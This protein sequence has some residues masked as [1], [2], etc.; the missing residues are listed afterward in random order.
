MWA[1]M[2]KYEFQLPVGG[3]D[4]PP[5]SVASPHAKIRSRQSDDAH[6]V[7][8]KESLIHY[9]LQRHLFKIQAVIQD[10]HLRQLAEA[11][12][13]TIPVLMNRIAEDAVILY[14]VCGDHRQLA[15]KAAA[16]EC[17]RNINFKKIPISKLFI[18]PKNSPFD[19]IIRAYGDVDN[20]ISSIHKEVAT[21]DLLDLIRAN[22]NDMIEADRTKPREKCIAS[23]KVTWAE[24]LQ[25]D[26]RGSRTNLGMYVDMA[27]RPDEQYELLSK[28]MRG[29]IKTSSGK[30]SSAVRQTAWFCQSITNIS[31]DV[32]LE[33]L[34]DVAEGNS[35]TAQ[36]TVE[37]RKHRARM[38]VEERIIETLNAAS[39]SSPRDMCLSIAKCKSRYMGF[40]NEFTETFWNFCMEPNQVWKS[41]SSGIEINSRIA[42]EILYKCQRLVARDMACNVA[43]SS[44]LFFIDLFYICLPSHTH[45]LAL[46]FGFLIFFLSKYPTASSLS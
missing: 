32:I 10:N 14:I 8:I 34:K 29:G 5:D 6:V 36:F 44:L 19:N 25:R 18:F 24:M 31:A 2:K 27:C 39:G 15:L 22:L 16:V 33:F 4:V 45:T 12:K 40:D 9:G 42:K 3:I 23:L 38:E 30:T 20:R 43:V 11:E 21:A 17:P 13:L 41:G 7:Q 28:I 35:T 26:K 1:T 37:C 46:S